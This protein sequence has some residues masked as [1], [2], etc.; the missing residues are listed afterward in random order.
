M[1]VFYSDFFAFLIKIIVFCSNTALQCLRG[2]ND[3]INVFC[4]ENILFKGRQ[5]GEIYYDVII[6]A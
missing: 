4:F 3:T 1:S 6:K 5:N 2:Y